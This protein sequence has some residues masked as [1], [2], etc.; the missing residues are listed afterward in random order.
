MHYDFP[1][2]VTHVIGSD[3]AGYGTLAGNLIIM[4]VIAPVSWVGPS[5]LN[6]SK[7]LT[8]KKNDHQVLKTTA[9]LLRREVVFSLMEYT[10]DDIERKG[11]G[12]CL[13]EGHR[14]VH[15]RLS[16]HVGPGMHVHHIADGNMVFPPEET[17][18]SVVKADSFIR[19]VMAASVLAKTEQLRQMALYDK[20][21]PAYGF[22]DHAGYPSP[23]HLEALDTLGP[24]SVHR[25][26]Y[27][28]V[29]AA[30]DK[31]GVV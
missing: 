26:S 11:V 10:P 20:R 8:D 18:V 1:P 27:A 30:C 28:P 25:R 5:Q 9:M 6:D 17:I 19:A 14:V 7:K 24:T 12:V 31:H 2:H 16:A 22:G 23:K 13:R 15:R 4:G 21:W 3:E 29:K